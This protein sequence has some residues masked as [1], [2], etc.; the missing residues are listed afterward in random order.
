[1]EVRERFGVGPDKVIEV[2]ALAGDPV[3]NV[4]GVP[5]IGVKTG[6]QLIAEFG[7]LDALLAR[8]HEI[9]Q[10]KRRENLIAFADQARLSRDL[11]RLKDDVP[12]PERVGDFAVR[13]PDPEVLLGFLREMGFRALTARVERRL[14]DGGATIPPAPVSPETLERRYEI[15]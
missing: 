3:D 6:A 4:P 15:V 5:G 9:R 13:R 7:S 12:M 10:P 14:A 11:V 2:Q 8:A 1:E